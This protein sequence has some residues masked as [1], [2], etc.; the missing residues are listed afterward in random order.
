MDIEQQNDESKTDVVKLNPWTKIMFKPRTTMR[1]I[2]NTNPPA[3]KVLFLICLVIFVNLFNNAIQGILLNNFSIAMFLPFILFSAIGIPIVYYLVPIFFKWIGGILGGKG[4]I[5]EIRYVVGYT[6]IP[7][8]Y[9]SLM[10]MIFKIVEYFSLGISTISFVILILPL[11]ILTFSISIW[12]FIISLKCLAEAHKFSAWK[13]LGT[14]IIGWI[15]IFIPLGI[16]TFIVYFILL[17]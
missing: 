3:G 17:L 14:L 5:K 9:S 6:S 15:I 12:T 1:Y 13:A 8:I 10:I 2:I 7:S 4:T 11:T 16:I